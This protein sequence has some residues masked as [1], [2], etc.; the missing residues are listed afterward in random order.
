VE[1]LVELGVVGVVLLALV[2]IRATAGHLVRFLDN[3]DDVAARIMLGLL[4]M[5]LMRSVVEVDVITPYTVGSFL[6][7]YS[8]ALLSAPRSA[9]VRRSN[10]PRLHAGGAG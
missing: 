2:L 1:V 7:Y 5:L 3:R 4:A 8:A 9:A 10:T 6:L